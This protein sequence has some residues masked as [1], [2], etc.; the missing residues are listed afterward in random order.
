MNFIKNYFI[1]FFVFIISIKNSKA[2]DPYFSQSL[3]TRTYLNPAIAGTDSTLDISIANLG[4]ISTNPFSGALKAVHS[5][6]DM[7]VRPLRG[8][9]GIDAESYSVGLEK[10][11]NINYSYAPHFELFKH[12][13]SLQPGVGIGYMK[14]SIP[15]NLIT[16]DGTSNAA[17]RGADS[18]IP[19]SGTSKYNLN[20]NLGVFMYTQKFYGG[21][22]VYHINQPDVGFTTYN[23]L[24]YKLTINAGANLS[25]NKAKASNFILSP[26]IIFSSQGDYQHLLLGITAKIRCV[27]FGF[28]Y[29]ISN[30]IIYNVGIQ[31]KY[32]KLGYSYN[33]SISALTNVGGGVNELQLLGFIPYRRKPCPIKTIRLI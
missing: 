2:Q 22:A 11:Y 18:G 26:N 9:I 29:D 28:N 14:T 31:F 1:L 3:F 4:Y 25:F 24:P 27:V 6:C 13:L 5:S 21:F 20:I 7:Y 30:S 17:S 16:P 10:S 15:E 23:P 8:G 12:K 32:F 33:K 19:W